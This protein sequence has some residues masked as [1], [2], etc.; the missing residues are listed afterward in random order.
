MRE[1]RIRDTLSGEPRP[2][3]PR[4]PPEVGIYACGPTVY[5]RIH[6]GNARPYVIFAAAAAASSPTRATS[7]RVVINVTDVNDKIYDAAREAGVPSAEHAARDDRRLPSRTPTGSGSG[8]PD[9]EPLATET[10]AEIVALI[11]ALIEGGHAYESGGD[12]YFRVRSFDGY[13]K[14][15]NR[16]PDEMDQGE[17]A[18]TAAAQGE[19]ARLRALEGAQG[20]R[21]HLLALAVGRGPPGLAHRV[22]GDGREAARRRLRD[23]RRRLRPR[24][25]PPRERDRADRGRARRAAGADLDAQRDGPHRRRRRCR[26]RSATSSSSPRRS[27][28]SAARRW[29]P[30]STSGHYR[31]PLEFSERGAG[32]RPRPGSSGS[33]TSSRDA[34]RRAGEEDP[35]VAER[36][37]AF[38][39][40]LADDFNTPRAWAA[41]F[42]LIAEGNRRPLARRARGAGRAAAAAR[43]RVAARAGGG[44]ADAEAEEL[45]AERERARA[46]RDF[47]ARR[48]DPRPSSRSS[49]GRCATRPTG[50]RLCRT[51]AERIAATAR[52]STAAGRSPRPSA[53]AA[54]CAGSGRADD[55][56]AGRARRGSRARPTTRGSSPRSTRIPTPTRRRC[57]RRRDA[58]VVAL[59]QVQDPHN[60]G[61]VAR[62]AEAA[63]RRRAGDPGAPRGVGDRRRRQGL[64]RRRRAPA[65]SPG[66]RTSPT[67]SRARRTPAPGSTAPRR[68]PRR[69]YTQADLTGKVVLVLGSEGK[70]LRRA[71]RRALR[72][73]GLDPGAGEGRLAERL[74]RR[75]GRCSSR[76]SA[77]AARGLSSTAR[78][79]SRANCNGSCDKLGEVDR[80][81]SDDV[82]YGST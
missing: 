68:T 39:A 34:R 38:L 58:L 77:S 42:E 82:D 41:L 1:V 71:G 46:E 62:S 80:T 56:D 3:E 40:A 73:A 20:G 76:R 74:G 57:S 47:D 30:T 53:A 36:R 69:P 79:R 63:G 75:R 9:A 72:R 19:P 22:L 33:A 17:E 11:E 18:G 65:R 26:S 81:M 51:G 59:D 2:L 12:V 50:A 13:G 23:P 44:G 52:S 29:S 32:A 4:E 60:L 28:A 37:E 55:T 70:G 5:S 67:G 8:R 6:V 35:F 48:R 66:S 21:G 54:G 15:S 25:P 45:L 49:A 7:R 64:R 16:D 78:G 61:A 31:Q 27:T 24:L 10:I 14:L 43:P